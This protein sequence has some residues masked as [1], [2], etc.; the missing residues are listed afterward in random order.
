MAGVGVASS[1][2]VVYRVQSNPSSTTPQVIAAW[3]LGG[4]SLLGGGIGIRTFQRAPWINARPIVG[5]GPHLSSQV[6]TAFATQVQPNR[7]Y[8]GFIS[9]NGRVR[10]IEPS[11]SV[12]GHLAAVRQGL[13]PS[14]SRGFNITVNSNGKVQSVYGFSELNTG[15]SSGSLPGAFLQ[16]LLNGLSLADEANVYAQ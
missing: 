10:F 14:G 9:P 8:M 4:V 3:S 6:R 1:A 15:S 16:G 11:T 13:V 5:A 2:A 12:P 7:A